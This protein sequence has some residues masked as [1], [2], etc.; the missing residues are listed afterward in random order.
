MRRAE[1]R[2]KS[3]CVWMR[4]LRQDQ[5]EHGTQWNWDERPH[6]KHWLSPEGRCSIWAKTDLC[7]CFYDPKTMARFRNTPTGS[8]S[9]RSCGCKWDPPTEKRRILRKLPLEREEWGRR[10]RRWGLAVRYH[11]S[12]LRCGRS[13]GHVWHIVGRGGM[14]RWHH[15]C[16]YCEEKKQREIWVNGRRID[17]PSRK[18]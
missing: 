10:K 11:Q 8:H 16:R 13:V 4:R 3:Y 12:C 5:N 15:R 1:R 18:G 14:D 17:L 2:W 7:A 9:N 6:D